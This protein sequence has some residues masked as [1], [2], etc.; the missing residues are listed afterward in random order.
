MTPLPNKHPAYF[1]HIM[2][3][4]ETTGTKP[5]RNHII[6][7]AAVRFNLNTQEYD[8]DLFHVCLDSNTASFRNYCPNTM[9]WWRDDNRA[10][11]YDRIIAESLSSRVC[12]EA[13]AT[14]LGTERLVFWGNRNGFDFMFLQSYFSDFN[15]PFPF[16]FWDSKDILSYTEGLCKGANIPFIR[17]NDLDF[18]GEK[19]NAKDD[20]LHQLKYLLHVETK[21][22]ERNYDNNNTTTS[23]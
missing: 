2:C 14:W 4:I 13:F 15:V 5:D 10:A 20:T 1:Q 9:A 12:I 19:H 16:K 17:K 11:I 8:P 21:I 18:V 3:D 22:K 23:P 6:E 7:L